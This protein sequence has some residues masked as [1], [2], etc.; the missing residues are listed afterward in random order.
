MR[1]VVTG[2]SGRTGRHVVR[3]LAEHG[4]QVWNVDR[5]VRPDLPARALCADL[6]DAGQ[7]Y[8]AFGQIRPEAVCHLAGNPYPTGQVGLDLFKTNVLTTYHVMQAAGDLGVRQVVYA[9]SALAS[10]WLDSPDSLPPRLPLNETHWQPSGSV[11]ALSKYVGEVVAA[12]MACRYPDTGFVSLR[13][14]QV[15]E[16]DDYG[17]LAYQREEPHRGMA[18]F[19][20]YIDA[21]DVASAFAMTLAAGLRGHDVFLIAAGDTSSDKPLPELLAEHFPHYDGLDPHHPPFASV[22]HC[23]KIRGLLGWEAVHSWREPG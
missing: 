20:S 14:T 17:L 15:I 18:S 12:S 9:S 6:L 7:V 16:P 11:Y 5:E 21:R 22:L 4:H 23:G 10:G 19:W 3:E 2:G 1:V 13:M 8:D